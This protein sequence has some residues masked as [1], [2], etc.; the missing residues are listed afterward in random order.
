MERYLTLVGTTNYVRVH[1][2]LYLNTIPVIFYLNKVNH[3]T[4]FFSNNFGERIKNI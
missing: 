3:L 2:R 1:S 4:Q